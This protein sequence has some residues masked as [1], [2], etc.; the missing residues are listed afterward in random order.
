MTSNVISIESLS[1][2]FE[3]KKE[4]LVLSNLSMQ[5]AKGEFLT[6]VGA[7]GSGKSTLLNIIAGLDKPSEGIVSVQGKVSLM[8]QDSTLLP[9]LTAL[10]NV[11]L[12]LKLVGVAEPL[13][14]QRSEELL[15]MVRLQDH[16][17]KKPHELSGGMKQRVAIARALSQDSSVLL[18]DEPFAALDAMTRDL[19][20]DEVELIA[21]ENNLT[22][23]FVTHNM[24]EAVRLG[25][26]VLLLG[27]NPGRIV[28]EERVDIHR[29]RIM[30]SSD[31]AS[32]AARLTLKLKEFS[33]QNELLGKDS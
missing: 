32:Y 22:V 6:L 7:S 4:N 28:H 21:K 12:A 25:D 29:T 24:R 13:R 8:F 18:M 30:D 2:S 23:V 11:K 15:T 17:N 10:E 14:T 20:H 33:G 31:V 26:R 5:V 9:W 19:M 1:K 27:H 16:M 3:S